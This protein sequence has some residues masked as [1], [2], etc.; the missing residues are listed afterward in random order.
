[1]LALNWMM[2]VWL[3]LAA[4]VVSC[5]EHMSLCWDE[6]SLDPGTSGTLQMAMVVA[7]RRKEAW[8]KIKAA[9]AYH[10]DKLIAA[11]ADRW[12]EWFGDDE[13]DPMEIAKVRCGLREVSAG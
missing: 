6:L 10:R 12:A 1:M 11:V 8:A 7:E 13:V 9:E 4:S 5:S 3:A 2:L